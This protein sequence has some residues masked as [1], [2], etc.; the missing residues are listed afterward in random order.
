V[1]TRRYVDL[2]LADR[3]NLALL[4]AQAPVIGVLLLLV[5]G[6]GA[7]TGGRIDAL[8]LLFMLAT[9]GVWFGVIN[10]AREICKE[11]PILERERLAGL[12]A[13]P[14]LVS[15]VV[16]LLG[17]VVVQSAMLVGTVAIRVKLP[18][19]GVLL[20]AP[21]ELVATVVLAGF[22]GLALGLCLSAFAVNPDKA[23]SMIPIVLVPQVLFAGV[24]FVL[25]GVTE[26][27]SWLTSSHAAMEALASTVDVNELPAP[28]AADPSYAHT[29]H[30]LAVA[31]GVLAGQ[32]LLFGGI[33]WLALRRKTSI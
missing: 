11:T 1:T 32:A 14:Y 3:R 26:S 23:T 31:W 18:G 20:P 29:A 4:L 6:E 19:A 8:K 28:L 24:M 27:V 13:G 25:H 17:L 5:S 22:A 33:A 2:V 15:K 9:T 7:L 16:V 21:I 30:N 10:S 12:R